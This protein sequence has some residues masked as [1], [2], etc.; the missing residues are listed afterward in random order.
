MI[1]GMI[2]FGCKNGAGHVYMF[3]FH[4]F[5]GLIVGLVFLIILVIMCIDI[6]KRVLKLAVLR[7]ISPIPILS[8]IGPNSD[9]KS[10]PLGSWIKTLVSTYAELFINLA[11]LFFA[12][13]L[14]KEMSQGNLFELFSKDGGAVGMFAK[15]FIYIALL[16][17]AKEAPKFIKQALGIKGDGSG[18]F[19]GLAASLGTLGGIGAAAAGGI[20]SGITHYRATKEEQDKLH[21]DGGGLNTAKGI[22]SGITGGF[23]SAFSGSKAAMSA[24]DHKI[25]AAR[26]KQRE[27]NARRADHSTFAGRAKDSIWEAFTGQSLA[28]SG[29]KKLEATNKA[30]DFISKLK[31]ATEE[32]GVK[33]GTSGVV[34]RGNRDYEFNY[35]K[36]AK[37]R[38]SADANGNFKYLGQT[39]NRDQFDD[40][41]MDELKKS[42]V[43]RWMNGETIEGGKSYVAMTSGTEKL[44]SLKTDVDSVINDA[45]ST[46]GEAFDSSDL[47]SYGRAIGAASKYISDTNA[48]STP[49]GMRQMKRNANKR[50]KN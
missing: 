15:V 17:F 11:V 50:N 9:L 19:S 25:S 27:I 49:E 46:V 41:F 24:K 33:N 20:G 6:A 39:Y 5:I 37:A 4:W 38:E 18:F 48:G 7:I 21:P 36:F 1:L 12:I 44:A 14:M 3:N 30:Q 22:L 40:L 10:G 26:Q 16:L 13:F 8:Y 2:N 23:S 45:D 29:N 47:G 35:S 31:S 32:E 28:D 42:Q 34:R 43:Q